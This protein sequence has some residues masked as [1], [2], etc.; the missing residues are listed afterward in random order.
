M[1]ELADIRDVEPPSR[2][3]HLGLECIVSAWHFGERDI[4]VDFGTWQGI[5]FLKS[6]RCL[7]LA[8]LLAL[9][10]GGDRRP[11]HKLLALVKL[12]VTLA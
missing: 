1:A 4:S 6:E 7:S 5:E 11:R 10:Q 9:C 3:R 2:W 12:P 8:Q